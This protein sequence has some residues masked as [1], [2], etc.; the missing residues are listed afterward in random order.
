VLWG[1]LI[2]NLLLRTVKTPTEAEI[3]KRSA[4]AAAALLVL[5]P[6]PRNARKER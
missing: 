4:E 1:D 2:V 3:V 6:A 5:H